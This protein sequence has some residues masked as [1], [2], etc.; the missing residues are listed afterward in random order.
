M[1]EGEGPNGSNVLELESAGSQLHT[2]IGLAAGHRWGAYV[3]AGWP[4]S[5]FGNDTRVVSWGA[6][7]RWGKDASDQIFRHG[8]FVPSGVNDVTL[9]PVIANKYYLLAFRPLSTGAKSEVNGVLTHTDIG[10]PLNL[11]NTTTIGQTPLSGGNVLAYLVI[12]T[13]TD[14]INE[15]VKGWARN[16][17]GL[18]IA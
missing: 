7:C 2:T 3:I 8:D 1:A 13:P 17:F 16:D 6:A 11:V 4:G 9:G 18:P 5:T 14:S 15:Y 10:E 12:D